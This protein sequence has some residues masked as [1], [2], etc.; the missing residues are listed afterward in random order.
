MWTGHGPSSKVSTT[1]LVLEEVVGLEMLEAEARTACGVDLDDARDAH[2]IRV[3]AFGPGIGRHIAVARRRERNRDG[4]G[5]KNPTS[6]ADAGD[7]DVAGAGLVRAAIEPVTRS[8]SA[9]LVGA[10]AATGAFA[11]NARPTVKLIAPAAS[12]T[13]PAAANTVILRITLFP[14]T[15]YKSP[16]A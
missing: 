16:G 10:M 6:G 9:T 13:A 1:S 7:C 11:V 2:R 3:G 12:T 5:R 8:A 14:R 15:R 4:G